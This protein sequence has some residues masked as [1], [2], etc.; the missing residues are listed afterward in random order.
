MYWFFARG[1]KFWPPPPPS[2]N[3]LPVVRVGH[4]RCHGVGERKCRDYHS[5]FYRLRCLAFFFKNE[6][7]K[8]DIFQ[9]VSNVSLVAETGCGRERKHAEIQIERVEH[10]KMCQ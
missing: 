6:M 2:V 9:V 4:L 5:G 3:L 1:S 7:R 8:L 10:R